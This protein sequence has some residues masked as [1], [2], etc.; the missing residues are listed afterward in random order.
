[1]GVLDRVVDLALTSREALERFSSA[2]EVINI[3][4]PESLINAYLAKQEEVEIKGGGKLSTLGVALHEGFIA[5]RA[6]LEIKGVAAAVRTQFEVVKLQAN[7]GHDGRGALVLRQQAPAQVQG[8][9]WIHKVII[10]V[11]RS[12]LSILTGKSFEAWVLGSTDGVD[13]VANDGPFSPSTGTVYCFDL[14]RLN[15][16][17]TLTDGL[18]DLVGTQSALARFGA[19]KFANLYAVTGAECHTSSL[20]VT[21]ARRPSGA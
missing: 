10:E 1:M 12:I 13:I 11:A 8:K 7:L 5:V 4:I 14:D 18:L 20:V 9:R 16:R 3:P 15:V 17:K 2:T 6:E 21:L 19:E